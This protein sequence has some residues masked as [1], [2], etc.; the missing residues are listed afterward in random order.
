V[1]KEDITG[2][3]IDGFAGP[4]AKTQLGSVLG[5]VLAM[6]DTTGRLEVMKINETRTWAPHS[7]H[8]FDI[9]AENYLEFNMET[10]FYYSPKFNVG[11]AWFQIRAGTLFYEGFDKLADP[12]N[13]HRTMTV[14]VVSQKL[15]VIADGTVLLRSDIQQDE[16]QTRIE[17]TTVE[18]MDVI[19][20][21]VT[22]TRNSATNGVLAISFKADSG[23]YE[24]VRDGRFEV[25]S[26]AD[27]LEVDGVSLSYGLITDSVYILHLEREGTTVNVYIQKDGGTATETTMTTSRALDTVFRTGPVVIG[28][29]VQAH[30]D[31]SFAALQYAHQAHPRA[32]SLT[33][34]R[35]SNGKLSAND[36]N[37]SKIV[38]TLSSD[39]ADYL[40]LPQ[41][42]YETQT[43]GIVYHERY[44][45]AYIRLQ[46]CSPSQLREGD[47][48]TF[49]TSGSQ[50]VGDTYA[51]D[52]SV[53]E[54]RRVDMA[55]VFELL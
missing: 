41:K 33:G 14:R 19:A 24:I 48:G 39:L 20:Y 34:Y 53:N 44:A 50:V 38:P 10:F 40:G 28:C 4:G 3:I 45:D 21:S 6:D 2:R 17:N 54:F 42:L 27:D 12:E 49:V 31:T 1:E 11:Q 55:V 7:V 25:T 47:T 9:S 32:V 35:Y 16:F 8:R 29:V 13:T 36:K 5:S 46:G 30:A 43:G 52:K 18:P 15:E 51:F 22:E 37:Y 26:S 23:S